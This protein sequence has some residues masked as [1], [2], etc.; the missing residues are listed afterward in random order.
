MSGTTLVGSLER[1]SIKDLASK[2]VK[3][4]GFKL[5]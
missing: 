2:F 5:Q 3:E 4:E 1:V